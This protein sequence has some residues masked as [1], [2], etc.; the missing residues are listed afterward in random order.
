MQPDHQTRAVT[1]QHRWH[2]RG[3]VTG[4]LAAVSA[5][6][7]LAVGSGTAQAAGPYPVVYSFPVALAAGTANP[8]G[9]PPGALAPPTPCVPSDAH[10]YPV[11]LVH[12]TFENR[13]DNWNALAPLLANNGYCVY[14]LNYGGTPGNPAKATGDIRTSARQLAR[15]V[16]R[17]LAATGVAKVDIV[18]H[19]QGGM[20]P[21]QYVKFAGGAPYVHALVGL[22]P[23]NR[24]TTFFGLLTLATRFPSG[25]ALISS[26]CTACAQQEEHSSFI[27]HLNA[28]PDP[29]GIFY[30][31]IQTRYDDVVTPYTN[32]FLTR[33]LNGSATNITLQ[34][35]CPLDATDHLGISYDQNALTDVLNALDPANQRPMPCALALPLNGG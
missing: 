19:S 23:S 4:L 10:P 1:R 32:A 33:P 24:G 27:R 18:G 35:Q 31:V 25:T 12:G 2:R 29:S 13:L 9:L 15:F 30:T 21:R 5:L 17:V 26:G 14:A 6:V 22:S 3:I 7:L 28:S 34:D 8:E 16:H 20:M 11:V